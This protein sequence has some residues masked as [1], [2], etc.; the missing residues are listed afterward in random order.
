MPR[1]IAAAGALVVS[2]DS[3]MNIA[4]PAIATAFGA[5]AERMRWVIVCYVLTY[6]LTA[7]AGGAVADRIGHVAVFRA[8]A[9]LSAVA[10]LMGGASVGFGWLLLARVV[11]GFGC[12]LVY[13]T[14][15]ALSTAGAP[16]ALRG[17]RLGFLNGAIAL[18]GAVGPVVAGVLVQAVGWRAVFHVRVPL[19]LA[20]LAGTTAT[21]RPE[22]VEG[23]RRAVTV[24]DVVR[25]PVLW[26]CV[27]A[28]VARGSI[29]AIW[30]LVPF[31]LVEGRGLSAT[32]GGLLFMLTPLGSVLAAPLAGRV[33]DRAG[34]RAPAFAG[35]LLEGFGLVLLATA[36]DETPLPLVSIALF[37]A[38]FGI[39][40]FEVPNMAVIMAGFAPGQQGAAG[41]LA[42]LART[43]GVVVGVSLLGEV[44]AA[45]QASV[46]FFGAFRECL[47]VAALAVVVLAV[48]DLTRRRKRP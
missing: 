10:F 36:G 5:P 20:V 11:Q 18:G 7:F 39:G 47:V 37:T 9:A 13:G 16:P 4:F 40:F 31:Y 22:P 27:L 23:P 1:W 45:R 21:L 2:L 30:L 35:L 26:A 28:F 34:V 3:M 15:P 42:F 12:G 38:G 25:R 8:G 17:R 24:A 32:V 41:G 48:L 14:A 29:F 33:A 43:L 19:A 46:G 6:A 44:F